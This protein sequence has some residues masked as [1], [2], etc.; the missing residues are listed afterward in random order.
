MGV[1]CFRYQW[2][3]EIQFSQASLGN[4]SMGVISIITISPLYNCKINTYISTNSTGKQLKSWARVYFFV[5]DLHF[6]IGALCV[7][8]HVETEQLC[9]TQINTQPKNQVMQ[10]ELLHTTCRPTN[11]GNQK[12]L[13]LLWTT[14]LESRV[15][16]QPST[17]ARTRVII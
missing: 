17:T 6:V 1:C 16:I 3:D 12:H 5:S 7:S 15:K 4:R 14:T 10:K 13:Y 8:T 11:L 2:D 9:W